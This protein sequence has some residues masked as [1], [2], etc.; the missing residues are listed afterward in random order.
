ML[1]QTLKSSADRNSAFHLSAMELTASVLRMLMISVSSIY[2]LCHVV[3]TAT[4][5]DTLGPTVW[6]IT[7]VL[8]PATGLAFWLLRRSLLL[9]QGIWQLGLLAA[10]TIG[11]ETFGSSGFAFLYVLLP[12]ISTI[13]VGW[14]AGCLAE[15]AVLAVLWGQTLWGGRVSVNQALEIGAGGVLTILMGWASSR[16]LYTVTQWSLFAHE[17][18]RHHMEEA[19]DRR[20][21]LARVVKDLDQAYHRLERTNTALIAAWRAADKAE[22]FR[23]EFAATLSHELRTPLNLIIGFSEMMMTC[24]ENYDGIALPGVYRSDLESIYH[25]TRHLLGLANDVLDIARIDVGKIGLSRSEVD[26]GELVSEALEMVKDYVTAK[27]L[28]L[29]LEMRCNSQSTV[30]SRRPLSNEAPKCWS[31]LR[32]RDVASAKRTLPGSLTSLGRRASRTRAVGLPVPGLA[33]RSVAS[34]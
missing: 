14:Q 19:R 27:G 24:P 5:P 21:Q 15:L 22:R 9:A 1:W 3:V 31:R 26:L 6:A 28:V 8:A 20:A 12:F 25:N 16:V 7:F 11:A 33:C 30:R 34:S 29:Q 17:H 10:I 2:V 13:V 23:A 18:A 32:T 4:W